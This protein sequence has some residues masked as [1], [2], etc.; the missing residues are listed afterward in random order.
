M[1]SEKSTRGGRDLIIDFMRYAAVFMM[2][3][4]H[5]SMVLSV[6]SFPNSV[7][8][9]LGNFIC[10][11]LFLFCF[12]AA[13]GFKARKN[14]DHPLR[15]R[16]A[17]KRVLIVYIA[18]VII[19]AVIYLDREP[20]NPRLLLDFVLLQSFPAYGEFLLAFILFLLLF[21]V[22]REVIIRHIAC[23]LTRVASVGVGIFILG[24]LLANIQFEPLKQVFSLLWG[25]ENV[26][27]FPVMQYMPVFLLGV[28]YALHGHV[29]RKFKSSQFAL[30]I[31]AGVL[32]VLILLLIGGMQFTR[33]PPNALFVT[34]NI[35]G[36]I[37]FLFVA[38]LVLA[39]LTREKICNYVQIVSLYSIQLVAL[40]IV[41]F[42][43]LHWLG[44][45]GLPFLPISL[46]ILLTALP[47]LVSRARS[48]YGSKTTEKN[49]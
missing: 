16:K 22:F 36:V 13:L 30:I 23:S 26:Y 49:K 46:T 20:G 15:W 41:V 25:Y 45:K 40:H 29:N 7:L 31:C 47:V 6:G 32:L 5:A 27:S 33:W 2:M 4:A 17:G 39:L 10:F 43:G 19:S 9:D 11:A 24:T 14:M 37:A 44:V 1:V 48:Y 3:F 21:A 35:V 28:Y 34:G 12:G 18:Y 38:R 8:R 42:F